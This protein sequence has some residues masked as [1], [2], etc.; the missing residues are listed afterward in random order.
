[1]IEEAL[2]FLLSQLK[3]IPRTLYIPLGVGIFGLIIFGYGLMQFFKGE[4]T[5]ENT[6]Q[7]HVFTGSSSSIKG[8]DPSTSVGMTTRTGKIVIDVE[9]S[10]LKPGVYTLEQDKRVQDALVA[11]GGLSAN[12]DRNWVEK[13]LNLAA[14][15]SDGSKI[16]IPRIGEQVSNG[17][18]SGQARMTVLGAQAGLISINNASQSDLEGLPGIGSVT[19]GKIINARPFSSLDELVTR[20]VVS[21]SVYEKIKD[22]LSL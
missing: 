12:A 15:I 21:K 18:D 13:Q 11:A 8:R 2:T 4:S 1:M 3:K 20:K 10:V 16:Y 17:G 14:K 6:N 9:G 22:K 5:R 19:A 7:P